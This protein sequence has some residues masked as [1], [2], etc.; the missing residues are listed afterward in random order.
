LAQVPAPL[1]LKPM[2]PLR[3]MMHLLLMALPLMAL[4]E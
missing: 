1:Q 2:R 3:L 4:M